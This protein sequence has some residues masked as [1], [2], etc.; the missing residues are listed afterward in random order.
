MRPRSSSTASKM[1]ARAGC[2]ARG[3]GGNASGTKIGGGD[4]KGVHMFEVS[5]LGDYVQVDLVLAVVC[6]FTLLARI[7]GL[8]FKLAKTAPYITNRRS[9]T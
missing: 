3:L 5:G 4:G 8:S 7:N 6:D 9:C 2:C 1:A